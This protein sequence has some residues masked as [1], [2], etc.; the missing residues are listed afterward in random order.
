MV[1]LL[2]I[3]SMKSQYERAVEMAKSVRCKLELSFSPEARRWTTALEQ[4]IKRLQQHN[5]LAT[6]IMQVPACRRV[7]EEESMAE[8]SI[9][10]CT[11]LDTSAYASISDS[12]MEM[13][14]EAG[15]AYECISRERALKEL[16]VFETKVSWSVHQMPYAI[17]SAS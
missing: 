5:H 4:A 13:A 10:R 3:Y 14:I 7:E 8:I 15:S 17:M 11:M 9:K 16:P 12:D 2:N 1:E 6:V